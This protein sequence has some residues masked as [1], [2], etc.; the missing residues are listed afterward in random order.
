MGEPTATD[1]RSQVPAIDFSPVESKTFML[2]L[3]DLG[4]VRWK[5]ASGKHIP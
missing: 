1:E 2:F 3:M 4:A 5:G